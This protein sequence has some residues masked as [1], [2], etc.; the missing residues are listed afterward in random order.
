M[1]NENIYYFEN[2]IY[3][4]K[5]DNISNKPDNILY[6]LYQRNY[7]AINIEFVPKSEQKLK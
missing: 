5:S 1:K 7:L 6:K 4:N 3:D 2:Q